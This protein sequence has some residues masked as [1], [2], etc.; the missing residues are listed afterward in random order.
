MAG[1]H[2]T[3]LCSFVQVFPS[4]ATIAELNKKVMFWLC[5]IPNQDL[6]LCVASTMQWFHMAPRRRRRRRNSQIPTR[7]V[8]TRKSEISRYPNPQISTF[9]GIQIPDFQTLL[10]VPAPVDELSDPNLTASTFEK[11][12]GEFILFV[13]NREGSGWDLRVPPAA[14]HM[15]PLHGRC[16]T[17]QQV[18]LWNPIMITWGISTIET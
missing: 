12:S 6:L 4:P 9:P 10:A 18:L 13:Y 14:R 15:D 11:G 5:G 8:L 16:S 7:Q 17:K 2:V 1:K 3:C